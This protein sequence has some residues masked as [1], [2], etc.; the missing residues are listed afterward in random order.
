MDTR[1]SRSL[2]LLIVP[3]AAALLT[4]CDRP[5][6]RVAE[7]GPELVEAKG[8]IAC[9]QANGKGIGPTFPNLGGQWESYLRMQLQKYRSG[10]RV[11]IIMNEQA[12][13]LTDEEI[14]ILAAWFASQ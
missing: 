8:C 4:A 10:E 2:R 12:K 5:A 11:N 13:A 3:A 1:I 7:L 6:D 14:R 9:H